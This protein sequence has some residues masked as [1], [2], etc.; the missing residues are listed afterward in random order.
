MG[1]GHFVALGDSITEGWGESYPG[2]EMLSWAE[3]LARAIAPLQ[4]G[5]R[6]T[7]LAYRG[8]TAAQVE[9][10]QFER[11]LALQPD[12]VSLNAGANDVLW[13]DWQA[14]DYRARMD[15]MLA[16]FADAG[17]T[18]VTFTLADSWRILPDLPRAFFE[19]AREFNAVTRE[20]S[21]QYDTVFV[22]F[23]AQPDLMTADSFGGDGIHPNAL[24][25]LRMARA[26]AAALSERAD[27]AITG[28]SL[29]LP[30]AP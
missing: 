7:N 20:L 17:A 12:L 23:W 19:P 5:F 16:A 30:A 1:W 3:R 18:L 29:Q 15:R 21:Q 4:S 9:A 14:D 26:L 8:L 2:L 6:F 27:L 28:P 11:A 10:T 25:Y 13:P 22:D 24:G